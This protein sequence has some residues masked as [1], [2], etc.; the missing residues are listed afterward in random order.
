MENNLVFLRWRA[1][2]A[3]T[4]EAIA[5]ILAARKAGHSTF[6][7]K[8]CWATHLDRDGCPFNLSR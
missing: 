8:P 4:Q 6:F 7:C 5:A 1:A 3:T 2:R